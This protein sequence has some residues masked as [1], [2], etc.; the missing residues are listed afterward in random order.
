MQNQA[1]QFT[2]MTMRQVAQMTRFLSS[3]RG[4]LGVAFTLAQW[5][6]ARGL[7]RER[8]KLGIQRGLELR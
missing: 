5:P 2:G 8:T 1:N 4:M 3:G 7:L 6:P